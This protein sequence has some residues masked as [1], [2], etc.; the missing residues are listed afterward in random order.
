MKRQFYALIEAIPH[1]FAVGFSLFYAWHISQ[2]MYVKTGLQFIAPLLV[3][4]I[5][6]LFWLI[7]TQGLP[8]G[9]SMIVYRRSAQTAIGMAFFILSSNLVAPMPANAAGNEGVSAVLMIVFC[10]T[11]VSIV[12]GVAAFVVYS[13]IKMCAA[14][15]NLSLI[16][17]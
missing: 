10:V 13:V 3:I 1:A 4:M 16:H 17:I 6:H 8:R 7:L 11:V 5:V 12:V 2:T 15:I 9:F 14:L